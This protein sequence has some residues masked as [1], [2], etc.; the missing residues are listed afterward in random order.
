[1]TNNLRNWI[2]FIQVRDDEHAQKE[3]REIATEIKKVL[4]EYFPIVSVALGW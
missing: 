2:H 3:V 4:K 1:M